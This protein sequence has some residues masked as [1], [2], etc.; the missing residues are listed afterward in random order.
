MHNPSPIRLRDTRPQTPV[1]RKNYAFTLIELLVVIAIIA[2]L[3]AI[4]FPV[5]A[6]AREKARQTACLSNMKQIGTGLMMYSQDYDESMVAAWYGINAGPSNATVQYKWMDALQPY[7][8]NEKVFDCPSASI[9]GP[10]RG[11]Y[12]FR[13]AQKYGSY[14]TSSAYYL[15]GDNYTPPGSHNSYPGGEVVD[16]AYTMTLAQVTSPA[17][18]AWISEG[19]GFA[20]Y[21]WD[22]PATNPLLKPTPAPPRLYLYAASP[23]MGVGLTARHMDMVNM[24]WCDGHVKAMR[25]ET[26]AATKTMPNGDKVM[27]MFTVE[28]D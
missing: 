19:D 17:S 10:D 28:D 11:D 12:K 4:L 6:K 27:T 22:T 16:P 8:K 20:E 24:I 18:T 23:T 25:L 21:A 5:F 1:L 14:C 13:T 26:L 15:A 3:A 9:E 7:V 2:I